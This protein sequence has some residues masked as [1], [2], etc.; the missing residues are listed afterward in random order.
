MTFTTLEKSQTLLIGVLAIVST[1]LWYNRPTPQVQVAKTSEVSTSTSEDTSHTTSI[2]TTTIQTIYKPNGEIVVNK[3]QVL[4]KIADKKSVGSE[5]SHK[6]SSVLSSGPRNTNKPCRFSL[7]L[8][9]TPHLSST[10]PLEPHQIEAG[11]RVISD[12]W[13]TASVT[14][15]VHPQMTVGIR[16]EW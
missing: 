16:Y 10:K 14:L 7:G 11:I 1:Y 5:Q 2:K 8:Q 9:F 13:L 12:A 4:Q 3:A 6:D 15:E